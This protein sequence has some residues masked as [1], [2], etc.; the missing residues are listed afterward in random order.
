MFSDHGNFY[1]VHSVELSF[2]ERERKKVNGAKRGDINICCQNSLFF[3]ASILKKRHNIWMDWMYKANHKSIKNKWG[4]KRCKRLKHKSAKPKALMRTEPKCREKE[5]SF[6]NLISRSDNSNCRATTK[7][8][9]SKLQTLKEKIPG[10][11]SHAR[12]HFVGVL[13]FN[14]SIAANEI[15][16]S[17]RNALNDE[18]WKK[19]KYGEKKTRNARKTKHGIHKVKRK[20]NISDGIRCTVYI[21]ECCQRRK[22]RL[23]LM[24]PFFISSRS[25]RWMLD[26]N[27]E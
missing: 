4:K 13:W 26:T 5:K 27:C 6:D 25:L 20:K 23:S 14:D 7:R 15:V 9:I 17:I 12:I 19:I 8:D 3:S 2:R 18:R 22:K 1:F 24:V 21:N 11:E 16:R 10:S